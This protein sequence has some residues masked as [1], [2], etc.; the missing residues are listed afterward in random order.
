M[1]IVSVS[2]GILVYFSIISNNSWTK[3]LGISLQKVLNDKSNVAEIASYSTFDL[4]GKNAGKIDED[5][6]PG[7]VNIKAYNEVMFYED[8][9]D[10]APVL[11]VT[12]D[13]TSKSIQGLAW[14][15]NGNDGNKNTEGTP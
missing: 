10:Q 14:E 13:T 4:N 2:V 3:N 1:S 11:R 8:D 15:D 6:A 12:C 7:N 5:S 9:T